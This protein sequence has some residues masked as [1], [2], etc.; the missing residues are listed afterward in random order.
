MGKHTFNYTTGRLNRVLD[1]VIPIMAGWLQEFPDSISLGQ[2]IAGF[3]PPPS[4]FEALNNAAE[5]PDI[6]P[7]GSCFGSRDLIDRIIEKIQRDN[8]MH[9]SEDSRF[10]MVT[11]GANMAFSH[12]IQA[13]GDTGDE[14][15][16]PVPY[17]FN[18]HM[19]VTLAGLVPVTVSMNEDF[20]LDLDA[21]GKAITPRTRA[22][23]TVSPNNP[24]GTV[25][26]E[27][28][29]RR[30]NQL[31][32]DH[33]LFHIADE[34]YEYFTYD[35]HVHFSPGAISGAEAHTISLF[36]LSKSYGFAGW[37]I[38][39]MVAPASLSESM[40]KI[41]DTCLICPPA[42]CQIA[43]AKAMESGKAWPDSFHRDINH[44][45]KSLSQVITSNAHV[46]SAPETG[47]AF[48]I[49]ARFNSY[50]TSESLAYHF[51]KKHRIA[52]LP[53][54][55]FGLDEDCYLRIS[56]GALTSKLLPEA[57]SRLQ[58]AIQSI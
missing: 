1:P 8:G 57:V 42:I 38:G 54:T 2:G 7:Y 31:C 33:G 58:N 16:L 45:R 29:L 24:T 19:A 49:L 21:L 26:P 36:S 4:V 25:F 44:A 23:V 14:I 55:T 3:P 41:Q 35:D 46:C 30:V 9:W 20:Q 51:I 18:H 6:N 32:A 17:Y 12:V 53:A 47:G 43:A 28:D 39:Y 34:A 37:R 13:I 27:E 10:I 22:I 11:A 5:R 50:H 48:Y 40:R 52:A 56:F 15:I